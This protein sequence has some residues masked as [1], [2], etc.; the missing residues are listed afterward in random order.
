[1]PEVLAP[2]VVEHDVGA[3]GADEL[4]ARRVR[5][6]RDVRPASLRELQCGGADRAGRSVD[7]DSLSRLKVGRRKNVH[8][9]HRAVGDRCGLVEVEPAGDRGDRCALAHGDVVGVGA[10][11]VSEVREHAEDPISDGEGRHVLAD[12]DDHAREVLADPLFLRPPD[13]REGASEVEARA[14]PAAIATADGRGVNPD[15]HLV[16]L[17]RRTLDLDELQHLGRAVPLVDDGSHLA[18]F[19]RMGLPCFQRRPAR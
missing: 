17:R 14:A 2:R 7:E 16:V 12:L 8:R 3:E 4:H 11:A 19:C 15:E 10:G 13:A 18:P 5:D 1:M 6:G 9:L